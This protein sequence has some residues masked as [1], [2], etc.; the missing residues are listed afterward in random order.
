MK[1]KKRHQRKRHRRRNQKADRVDLELSS[2]MGV[3]M[4]NPLTPRRIIPPP[5]EMLRWEP[6]LT[7]KG[8][9]KDNEKEK[10]DEQIMGGM[11]SKMQ[12]NLKSKLRRLVSFCLEVF[13]AKF[14]LTLSCLKSTFQTIKIRKN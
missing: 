6:S 11:T 4:E 9:K 5:H 14:L 8:R 2:E 1:S 12:L 13:F 7:T 10:N 3:E